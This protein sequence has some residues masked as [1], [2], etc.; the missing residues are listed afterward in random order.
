MSEVYISVD[1]EASGPLPGAYSML[2]LG[3]CKVDGTDENFYIELRPTSEA[4]VPEAMEVIGRS[5][6]DFAGKGS[7]PAEAMKDFH[8]W[9]LRVS[10]GNDPVFVGFNAAFD[11]S[12]INWYFYTYLGDNPFGIGGI[13]IKSFYMGMTGCDWGD[14]RSSRIPDQFKGQSLHTHNALDDAIE[15]AEMFGLMLRHVRSNK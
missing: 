12:F 3:A 14:T 6:E 10:S 9:V 7:S 15:Q 1:I 2:S 4:F 8:D 11:W 5:L 13:D